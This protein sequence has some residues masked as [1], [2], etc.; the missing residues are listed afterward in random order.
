MKAVTKEK[1]LKNEKKIVG[2]KYVPIFFL[3]CFVPSYNTCCA[4]LR[5]FLTPTMTS[6][7]LIVVKRW[8]SNCFMT[9][10]SVLVYTTAFYAQL[11]GWA[12]GRMYK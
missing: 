9:A 1:N 5:R 4:P 10:V 11:D 6:Y 3:I 8:G 2:K 7:S 12:I